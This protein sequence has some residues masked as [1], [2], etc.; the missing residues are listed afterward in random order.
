MHRRLIPH[1][2]GALLLLPLPA[3]AQ[4]GQ[5][6]PNEGYR[7]RVQYGR[8]VSQLEGIASLGNGVLPG[9]EFDVKQDLGMADETTWYVNGTIR[10]GA[11]W[12]LRGGYVALDYAGTTVLDKRIRLGDTNFNQNETVSSTIKGGFWSGDLEWDFVN[13]GSAYLGVTGGARAPD[14]DTVLVSPDFGKREQGTYRPVSP[15][16]GLAG[17]A[18]AGRVSLEGFA[19]TFARVSGNKVTDA[20]ITARLHFSRHLNISGGYH[21]ISF[22]AEVDPDLA[23]FKLKGWT[24]GLELGF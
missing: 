16:L 7:I 9:T 19:A 2:A 5:Q 22:S 17:R 11:K 1:L 12:K 4:S 21:Y 3:L 8:F 24:Y 23:D 13:T 6:N 14:V 10:L 18:Y 15:V 20:E